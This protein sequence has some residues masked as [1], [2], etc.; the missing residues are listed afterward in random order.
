MI[1]LKGKYNF[2]NVFIDEIDKT[3]EEQIREFLN[4]PMFKDAYIA[5]MPDCH[6]GV[7]SC[8]GFTMKIND[9]IIPN[10]IGVDLNCGIET[11]NLGKIDINFKEFDDFVRK[12]I[13]TGFKI[14]DRIVEPVTLRLLCSLLLRKTCKK[15]NQEIYRV[16]RSLGTLGGGNHFIE[17]N[18]DE[19]QNKWLTIH[20][21][22]RNFGHKIAT[23]YQNKAKE[24]IK[25]MFIKD[26]PKGLEFL[27][28][29]T[30]G[31]E[32]LN[33]ML[34]A[35]EYAK[36]NRFC[37]A[38]ILIKKYFKQKIENIESIKSVHNYVDLEAKIIRKGAISA[39]KGERCIIPFNMRDGV[40]ICKGKGSSEYNFSAPHGAGRVM[41]RKK[42]KETL[43]LEK[44]KKS[45]KGI[46]SST[47]NKETLDEAPNVYKRKED[48]IKN[49][50]ETVDIEFFMR[51]IYN[52]K[53]DSKRKKYSKSVT[54]N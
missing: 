3:T 22:S 28:K 12:N 18:E 26:I 44:F 43:N 47:I 13:P 20:T 46:W 41:S 6:R 37:I 39:Q 7:G 17:I 8:I 32:Y 27:T 35:Q 15:T 53:D 40:A 52:F 4:Q 2:A 42:A 29:E 36:W 16:L 11:Y 54:T 10:L 23:Y 25:K 50:T 1:Q 49:I 51:T 31:K 33:D 9:Y 48:I 14:H 24:L 5:I 21:G 30:G 38:Q 19:F 34:I 45:M